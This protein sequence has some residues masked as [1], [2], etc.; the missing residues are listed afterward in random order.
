MSPPSLTSLPRELRQRI[1]TYAF[2]DA[3]ERDL[4][5]NFSLVFSTSK[6]SYMRQ[7]AADSAGDSDW[8]REL[9][10]DGVSVINIDNLAKTLIDALPE[11]TDDVTFVLGK[12][13]EALEID[14]RVSEAALDQ[15]EADLPKD[16]D[17]W[18]CLDRVDLDMWLRANSLR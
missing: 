2:E 18:T 13:L 8:E 9:L 1:L 12:C 4:L 10:S 17:G 5:F 11:L 3:K 7:L 15:V 6:I 14:E 16:E